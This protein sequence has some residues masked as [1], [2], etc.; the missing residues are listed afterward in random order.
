[1]LWSD[2]RELKIVLDIDP[3]DTTQDA[4][5][6]FYNTW[7][8]NLIEIALNRGQNGIFKKSRTVY[9]NGTGTQ[10]LLLPNRP[11]YV[12]PEPQ[13]WVD[14]QGYWGQGSDA[15]SSDALT[16]GTSY[17]VEIDDPENGVGQ[18][19]ILFKI[20]GYWQKPFLRQAGYLSSFL[21]EGN[22]NI[23]ITYTGGWTYDNAPPILRMA[24]DLLI[25]KLS[26]I[27]PLGIQLS[28]ESYE[29]RSI[30]QGGQHHNYLM[31]LIKPILWQFGRNWKW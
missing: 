2:I 21:G 7:A 18:S 1:M 20:D 17:V 29:E 12:S 16:Y 23:K 14:S 27:F 19:G 6:N 31:S 11:V 4:K 8:S 9:L 5:L 13:V 30:S 10:K 3:A 26:Y 28:S 24:A 22:G 15:F 25:A